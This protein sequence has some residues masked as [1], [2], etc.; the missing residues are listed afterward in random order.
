MAVRGRKPKPTAL[1]NLQGTLRPA[2]H[3]A[4]AAEP[5]VVGKLKEAPDWFSPSQRQAWDYALEHAPAGVLGRIDRGVLTVWV[6]AED[7][8]RQ[9]VEKVAVG[10]LIVRSPQKGEPIQNPYLP[11]VNKQ[12]MIMLK[13]AAELGFSPA[14]RP[15]VSA[16]EGAGRSNPFAGLA[17]FDSEPG[18]D[19]AH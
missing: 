14:A 17:E 19:R 2:R 16:S 11:V 15:R 10:G 9:A 8:H 5:Q 1:H 4:R 7:L 3:A 13:A 6:V 12:A 18:E